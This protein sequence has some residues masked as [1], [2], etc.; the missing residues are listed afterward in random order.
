MGFTDDEIARM[1][2]TTNAVIYCNVSRQKDIRGRYI[3]RKV[4]SSKN[5]E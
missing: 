2:N 1:F 4:E 5:D 3:I